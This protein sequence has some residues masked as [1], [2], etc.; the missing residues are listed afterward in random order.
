[1]KIEVYTAQELKEK[2]TYLYPAAYQHYYN[3]I[4]PNLINNLIWDNYLEPVK[5]FATIF[6]IE[7]Y[8]V[9]F[10][11][12]SFK[13]DGKGMEHVLN[14]EKALR[15][16]LRDN[17]SSAQSKAYYSITS[18][19]G[20]I[21]SRH[22]KIIIREND[23]PLTGLYT[24]NEILNPL[25]DFYH[26]WTIHYDSFETLV[27]DCLNSLF[28][29]FSKEK[30]YINSEEAFLEYAEEKELTFCYEFNT[31]NLPQV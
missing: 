12:A 18:S 24:D 5:R 14:S 13:F 1:M 23:C 29:L 3:V 22:S 27:S 9:D 10:I 7:I 16:Y 30:D 6:G 21:K 2:G 4:A 11:D 25:L 20:K 17:I 15:R 8:D 28:Q 19:N 26:D 31:I